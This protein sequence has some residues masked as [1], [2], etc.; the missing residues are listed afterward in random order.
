M[1][2]SCNQSRA[3][4]LGTLGNTQWVRCRGCGLEFTGKEWEDGSI[5]HD[6]KAVL[7][8]EPYKL[9]LKEQND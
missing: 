6:T 5:S 1:C 7:V 9:K 2:P 8:A 3:E 4:L